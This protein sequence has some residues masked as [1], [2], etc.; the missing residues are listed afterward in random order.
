VGSEAAS[1]SG[2]TAAT[3]ARRP[4]WLDVRRVVGSYAVLLALGVAI[5]IFSVL[6]PDTFFTADN[7][8]TILATQA[9][10][11]VLA[12]GV[13]L[14]LAAG[15]FDLSSAALLGFAASLV[16]HV[17]V[18]VGWPIWGA[19]LLSFAVAATVGV[20]NGIFVVVFGVNSFITTLGTGT[21]ITGVATAVVGA[22]TIGG[23]SSSLTAPMRGTFL[24]IDNPVYFALGL[25]ILLWFLL[26]HTQIGRYVVF[27]GEGR[28]AARLAGVPVNAMR[29]ATLVASSITAWFGGLILLGQTGAAN[30]SFGAPFLLP[31]FAAGFLGATTIR[32]GRYNVWGTV[33]A[34]LL[35]AVGTTGLQL[36][37]AA[38]WVSDVFNGAALVLAVTLARLVSREGQ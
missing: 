29:F 34:V 16:A 30:T 15:E 1:G 25:A 4:G 6:R 17:S 32:P 26:E 13:T 23:V 12:L 24:G 10:L 37:G 35:L 38:D 5:L 28:E 7:F 11:V 33:V 8:K 2:E 21:L 20:A 18:A 31:A 9:V 3:V 22:T 27:A 36:L 14:P 19:L